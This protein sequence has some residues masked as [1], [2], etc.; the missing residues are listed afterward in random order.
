MRWRSIGDQR[1]IKLDLKGVREIW[2]TINIDLRTVWTGSWLPAIHSIDGRCSEP[3]K[4]WLIKVCTMSR[5]Q[6]LIKICT[7]SRDQWLIKV[8]TLSRDHWLIK[9]C[10]MSHDQWLIKVCTIS[11]DQWLIKVCTMSPDQFLLDRHW[12]RLFNSLT[13]WCA[14]TQ[15]EWRHSHH[16]NNLVI[17]FIRYP[18]SNHLY[19]IPIQ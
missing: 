15:I 11:R 19:Q 14:Q 9:V 5:D 1:K 10:T 17:I 16:L 13:H 12:N 7:M 3:L 4:Y 18:S 6:W 8:C 2:E